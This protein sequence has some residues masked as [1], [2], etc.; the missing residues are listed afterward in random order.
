MTF[1][2][3]TQLES[4]VRAAMHAFSPLFGRPFPIP[5]INSP[6]VAA[7]ALKNLSRHGRCRMRKRALVTPGSALRLNGAAS[8]RGGSPDSPV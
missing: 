7:P 8:S 3:G 1:S 6:A 2:S 4:P 5:G